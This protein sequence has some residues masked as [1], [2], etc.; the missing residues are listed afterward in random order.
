MHQLYMPGHSN[1][2]FLS[3]G[4]RPPGP[5]TFKQGSRFHHPKQVKIVFSACIFRFFLPIFVKVTNFVSF[6]FRRTGLPCLAT[7]SHLKV[8]IYTID[9]SNKKTKES[10]N[11]GLKVKSVEACHQKTAEACHQK[12]VEAYHQ[13]LILKKMLGQSAPKLTTSF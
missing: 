8:S 9:L 12:S 5:A 7:S 2:T 10:M 13:K 11:S 3:P 1:L 4:W 6:Q